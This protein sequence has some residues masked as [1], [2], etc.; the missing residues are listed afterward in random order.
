MTFV[1]VIGTIVFVAVILIAL[2][3]VIEIVFSSNKKKMNGTMDK[4][5]A[6]FRKRR[7]LTRPHDETRE[8]TRESPR[9]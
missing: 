3:A 9:R 7:A 8:P 5:P 4:K 6:W 2:S 1:T